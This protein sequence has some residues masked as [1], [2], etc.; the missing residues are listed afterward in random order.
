[1]VKNVVRGVI[2]DLDGTLVHI[3]V[4]YDALA[5]EFQ[6]IVGTLKLKPVTEKVAKLDERRR[7]EVFRAWTRAEF[8]A[9]PNLVISKEGVK[10]YRKFSEK[11]L[12]LVTMQGKATVEKIL[13]TLGLSFDVVI[14]REDSLNRAKQIKAALKKLGLKPAEA[15]MIGDRESDRA[16]SEK[17][18]CRFLMVSNENP[19]MPV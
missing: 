10:L 2:F 3:P 4:D 7:K 19:S 9:L 12:A 13:E 5:K 15:L 1:M 11:K 6:K 8:E 16:S 18:G 14:T 17:V